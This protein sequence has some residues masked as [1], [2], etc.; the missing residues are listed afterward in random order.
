MLE[1]SDNRADIIL[2]KTAFWWKRNRIFDEILAQIVCNMS[3]VIQYLV[4]FI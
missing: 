1:N 4:K 2:M 3:T